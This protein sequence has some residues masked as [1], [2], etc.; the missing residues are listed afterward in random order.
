[1]LNANVELLEHVTET[2]PLAGRAATLMV[3]TKGDLLDQ[4][5]KIARSGLAKYFP[6]VEVVSD[7]TRESLCRR[8]LQ[9][10]GWMPA[11]HDG[12]QLAALGYSAGAG[13][14]RER[15]VYPL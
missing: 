8:V 10:G 7:K 11:L 5:N 1:M 14:G 9:P 4:E 2:I 6:Q 3:I 13:I 15:G 12:G